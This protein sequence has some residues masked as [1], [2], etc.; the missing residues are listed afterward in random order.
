MEM[1]DE[2]G[3]RLQAGRCWCFRRRALHAWTSSTMATMTMT[4]EIR[5]MAL[6]I[7]TPTIM[8]T[9]NWNPRKLQERSIITE[10]LEGMEIRRGNRAMSA[11]GK[12]ARRAL[13]R[14]AVNVEDLHEA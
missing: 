1:C 2:Q 8:D 7:K 9:R 12:I 11:L 14:V 5:P 10:M 3:E 13:A 6:T 4:T